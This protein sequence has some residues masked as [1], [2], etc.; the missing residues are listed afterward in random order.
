MHGK[1]VVIAVTVVV[2]RR[3]AFDPTFCTA[4]PPLAQG[5]VGRKHRNTVFPKMSPRRWYHSS[6]RRVSRAAHRQPHHIRLHN[7]QGTGHWEGGRGASAW[8]VC[9]HMYVDHEIIGA[10]HVAVN[11]NGGCTDAC[12]N[13][14]RAWQ[15]LHMLRVTRRHSN[16]RPHSRPT[17]LHRRAAWPGHTMPRAARSVWCTPGISDQCNTRAR[18]TC[19]KCNWGAFDGVSRS[20]ASMTIIPKPPPP[21]PQTKVDNPPVAH[22]APLPCQR[23]LCARQSARL[24]GGSRRASTTVPARTACSASSGAVQRSCSRWSI[25]ASA[26]RAP[27]VLVRPMGCEE[28]R[29]TYTDSGIRR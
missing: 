12:A 28:E 7:S 2:G 25:T 10:A 8:D 19:G 5:Q 20:R 15:A 21:K 6:G 4:A 14:A 22:P 11:I 3:G 24:F 17:A 16:S 1:A 26:I 18:M 13:V 29:G 9:R 23:T 27:C